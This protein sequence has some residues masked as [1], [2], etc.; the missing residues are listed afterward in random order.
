MEGG[1]WRI[2]L[3]ERQE[4]YQQFIREYESIRQAE[5]RGMSQPEYYRLLPDK[6]MTGNWKKDWAIRAQSYKTF[7]DRFL[8]PLEQKTG[9]PLKILDLGAG[10]GWLSNRLTERGHQVAAIDILVNDTD[11]LGACRH[12]KSRFI[13][14]QAEFDRLPLCDNQADLIIYN[15][16][17]HYST[18][19]ELSLREAFRVLL[20]DGHVAIIDTP[21]YHDSLSGLQMVQERQADFQARFGIRSDGLPSQ[22]YLTFAWLQDLAN[23]FGI[24]W[25]FISPDYGIYWKV[26][27]IL[28]RIRGSREPAS[29][30]V[31]VGK[32][33]PI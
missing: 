20:A 16:S 17:F 27:P 22:N 33:N 30:L 24:S 1:V 29:F 31:I 15:A 14:I 8:F 12:Y 2:L 19:Y 32:N 4:Y 18:N 6:D 10:N 13:P 25:N 11:G 5:G 3:P 9:A 23:R 21:L 28:A 7:I 26:R